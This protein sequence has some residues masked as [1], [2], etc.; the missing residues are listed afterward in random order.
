VEFEP[1][2]IGNLMIKQNASFDDISK[3]LTA[4]GELSLDVSAVKVKGSV[5]YANEMKSDTYSHTFMISVNSGQG[6]Y[7]LKQQGG[8]VTLN[9]LGV[10]AKGLSDAQERIKRC[11]TQFVAR[12][13]LGTSFVA[14]LKFEFANKAQKDAFGGKINLEISDMIKGSAEVNYALNTASEDANVTL[15]AIQIGGDATSLTKLISDDVASCSSK[16]RDACKKSIAKIIEYA[17]KEF[18]AQFLDKDDATKVLPERYATMGYQY[19]DYDSVDPDWT[20]PSVAPE[21]LQA[22]DY[23][24]RYFGELLLDEQ[25]NYNRASALLRSGM[26]IS[27]Q[28]LEGIRAV[29]K[30]ITDR[31]SLISGAAQACYS[32]NWESCRQAIERTKQDI[33]APQYHYD[34]TKLVIIPS[35]MM[36]WCSKLNQYG[37][38]R[39]QGNL[40]KDDPILSTILTGDEIATLVK[41]F[42]E[43]KPN[44]KTLGLSAEETDPAQ[45]H[46]AGK[47]DCAKVDLAIRAVSADKVTLTQSTLRNIDPLASLSYTEKL[48]LSN[49]KIQ[50]ALPLSKLNYL[51]EVDLSHNWLQTFG[52]FRD[53]YV[54][55]LFLSDNHLTHGTSSSVDSLFRELSGSGSL[56]ELYLENNPKL[57][58]LGS[59]SNLPSLETLDLQFTGVTAVEIEKLLA[60][61]EDFPS[62]S[63]I[64]VSETKVRD[65]L[66]LSF[67]HPEVKCN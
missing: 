27:P 57:R 65:C 15:S 21:T 47:I 66:D 63:Q 19:A 28:E 14:I 59:L 22:L 61:K 32:Y 5:T 25:S 20:L 50:D 33:V 55:K 10:R 31:M 54:A 4:G 48:D 53:T 56:T 52:G 43:L 3:V 12:K 9:D 26:K 30:V 7:G 41:I 2:S 42:A 36:G 8:K 51:L 18:P 67:R 45:Y 1:P 13:S 40:G 16:N 23:N 60:R 64:L 58:N 6:Q 17:S 24:R 44:N 49:N 37:Y 11:G 62:L 34:V 35:D 38:I 29:Q 39:S 46:I